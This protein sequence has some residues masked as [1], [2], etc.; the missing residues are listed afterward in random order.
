MHRV[1][2]WLEDKL[3]V[4]FSDVELMPREL[5]GPEPPSRYY[6][7]NCRYCAG[8]LP[9]NP[10]LCDKCQLWNDACH[11]FSC[12]T[13]HSI[14]TDV[15]VTKRAKTQTVGNITGSTHCLICSAITPGLTERLRA[16]GAEAG[17]LEVLNDGAWHYGP[18]ER[19]SF[20]PYDSMATGVHYPE[21]LQ[22]PVNQQIEIRCVLLVIVSQDAVT[23]AIRLSKEAWDKDE[24][25]PNPY[26]V[27]DVVF[28]SQVILR[29]SN[30]GKT[31]VDVQLYDN[32]YIDVS[33]INKWRAECSQHRKA[34]NDPGKA[35]TGLAAT[36][37]PAKPL[38]ENFKLIDVHRLCVVGLTDVPSYV[39]LSYAWRA[40]PYTQFASLESTTLQQLQAA[41]SIGEDNMPK[42]LWDAILLCQDL[43]EHYLWVDRLCI[44]QDDQVAKI[45]QINAMD[46]I[47]RNASTTLVIAAD[48]AGDSGLPGV[49]G[50]PRRNPC[51]NQSRQLSVWRYTQ[52]DTVRTIN[53]SF[54]NTRGWTFQEQYLSTTCIVITDWQ[55]YLTC[56]FGSV[57]EDLHSSHQDQYVREGSL[58]MAPVDNV[59]K[60]CD[61]QDLV[62]MYTRRDLSFQS[63]ILNAFA[64]LG[65]VIASQ[66]GS[67]MLFG[68]PETHLQEALLWSHAGAPQR[69]EGLA[70]IP[71][72][73]WAAWLGPKLYNY[74]PRETQWALG[75]I[76]S[77]VQFSVVQLDGSL[78]KLEF[79]AVNEAGIDNA[80]NDPSHNLY[81]LNSLGPRK[82]WERCP[83]NPWSVS[84]FHILD[85]DH[86]R[87]ASSYPGSL[88]FNTTVASLWL[89]KGTSYG[90]PLLERRLRDT[91]GLNMTDTDRWPF[92]SKERA[93]LCKIGDR[94]FEIR[95]KSG[96]TVGMLMPLDHD[97]RRRNI[98]MK[99][100]H[101]F[102]VICPGALPRVLQE[103][104]AAQSKRWTNAWLLHVMLIERSGEDPRLA[105]RVA[106]GIVAAISWKSCAPAW[107]TV[108]LI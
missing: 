29:Y 27:D 86:A 51:W 14:S 55:V 35:G 100:A 97:W 95:N 67:K 42:M 103:D 108:V 96:R 90:T 88:V 43:G 94:Q 101:E 26:P 104:L 2:R 60:M 93:E 12:L 85:S 33:R 80:A 44:Q 71:S 20:N 56:P 83:H 9:N 45:Q 4:D 82:T 23:S 70:G 39:A 16:V 73:S 98:D 21:Q 5:T 59:R 66:L 75:C 61:Y 92:Y 31:L 10:D 38:P 47:Y 102:I 48:S 62:E 89:R 68:M 107:Q 34:A 36:Q 17:Q 78:R 15:S 79:T 8:D 19:P 84:E 77:L 13:P 72:W 74:I 64:G 63:D 81:E 7:A 87:L 40:A 58:P 50:R 6:D 18:Y 37:H 24:G 65:N 76:G 53:G 28:T 32:T 99:K 106:T 49:R 69:R 91:S 11:V 54:W 57:Q 30:Y 25:G 52:P 22:L 1:K 105:R 46:A 41:G 3:L